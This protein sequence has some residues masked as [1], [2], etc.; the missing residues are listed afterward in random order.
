MPIAECLQILTEED[1]RLFHSFEQGS[2]ALDLIDD[3]LISLLE[4]RLFPA[5]SIPCFP[6]WTELR[7]TS[8]DPAVFYI[9]GIEIEVHR[10]ERYSTIAKR[11]SDRQSWIFDPMD[12]QSSPSIVAWYFIG[13]IRI[14][15]SA[16]A[17]WVASCAGVMRKI[18]E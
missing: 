14:Q 1:L 11:R 5:G 16:Y 4:V 13:R 6:N 7:V 18:R 3:M 17:E 2:N 12:S 15:G 8:E 9:S 10:W